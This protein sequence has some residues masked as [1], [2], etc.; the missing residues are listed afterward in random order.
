MHEL[1]AETALSLGRPF[2]MLVGS[3]WI[4]ASQGE[5]L[6]V[7]DPATGQQFAAIPSATADDANR[8][9]IAARTAFEDGRWRKLTGSQRS[10]ILWRVAE[11]IE[12]RS[13]ELAELETLD[14]GKPISASRTVDIP[15]A[16]GM[17]RYWAGWCTRLDGTAPAVD[18]PGNYAA[19]T[20]LEPVGVAA[21]IVP[22]NFPIVNAAM[23]LA[24][25]LAAGCS[26]VLKPAEL[27]S[28]T[29][30]RLGEILLEAGIP[31]GTV[32]IVSGLGIVVGAA[33]ANNPDVDKISFTGS[34][35]VGKELL[36]A[37]RGNLK[38]L[39]LELGGKSPT[40]IMADADLSKAI[41]SAAGGIFRNSG[42]MCAAG[43]RILVAREVYQE[44]LDGLV[45]AAA[46][47][48]LG[49]GIDPATTMG[50][51][52]SAAQ[53]RRVIGYADGAMEDGARIVAGGVAHGTTG[54]FVEPTVI[55]DA[56]PDSRV[57]REEVFGPLAVVSAFDSETEAIALAN[58]TDF[59][60]SAN[61]WTSNISAA[62][63][64]AQ[65]IRVGTV[66]INSGMIVGPNLAF[67]GFKQSG[68]GREGTADGIHAYTEKKTIITAF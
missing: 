28:L 66:T 59:G 45:N 23:K 41:P 38:R 10:R 1:N 6:S 42:Q 21:L 65:S 58:A 37:A 11:L 62:Q 24:P 30:I 25:A 34:T 50:P 40:I 52:I 5:T 53:Q 35:A 27:S 19:S 31:P 67:G 2:R 7:I 39:T 22:W 55:A 20:V 63:R 26:V 14:A 51:V 17:F 29:A 61:V 18:L 43:S 49:P 8:A 4:D 3:N 64:L 57:A 68:W 48:R 32:N 54:Y 47:L 16:A 33:L 56:R 46:A 15:A 60:L 13:T 12:Q 9:V 44:V 36:V